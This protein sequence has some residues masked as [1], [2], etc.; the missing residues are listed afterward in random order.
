MNEFQ[1]KNVKWKKPS[2]S[3]YTYNF[4]KLKNKTGYY[5]VWVYT[6]KWRKAF[7]KIHSND[8]FKIQD[9]GHLWEKAEKKVRTGLQTTDHRLN[10]VC[11][12]FLHGP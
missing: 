11:H 1:E 12:L 2:P 7:L 10:P 8:K 4:Y 5:I 3:L 6:H 9:N